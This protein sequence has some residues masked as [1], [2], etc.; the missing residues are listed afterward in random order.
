M[1]ERQNW[2]KKLEFLLA[3]IGYAVGLGNVWRFPYLCFRSGGGSQCGEGNCNECYRV[4]PEKTD[5]KPKCPQAVYAR[6]VTPGHREDPDPQQSG[7]V[8]RMSGCQEEG[9]LTRTAN[10]D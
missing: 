5:M 1:E 8:R 2:S 9:Q 10:V 4:R 6:Q 3:T 7:S